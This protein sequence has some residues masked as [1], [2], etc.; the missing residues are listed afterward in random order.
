MSALMTTSWDDGYPADERLAGLLQRYGL[1]GTF[2]VPRR[3]KRPV[4]DAPR[5]RELADSFELGAHTIN[6]IVLPTTD[7]E[8]ARTEIYQSKDWIEQI[9]GENCTTFCF[10]QGKFC[11]RH[12][13][14]AEK[15]GFRMARTV[16]LMATS[17]PYR[18]AGLSL[19][20]TTLQAYPHGLT[21]YLINGFRRGRL[22]NVATAV[23]LGAV[24]SDW[25]TRGKR[26]IER[27]VRNS[28]VFHLWG[29]SWELDEQ[30]LW[31]DV[32]ELFRFMQKHTEEAPCVVNTEVHN[33]LQ[34]D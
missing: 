26:L 15:A 32:E 10:P 17:A 31:D 4:L 2:Y 28:G 13:R 11:S 29:H 16:E 6:H 27:V 5:L 25:V 14:M 30:D 12:V 24:S 7:D 1:T 9:T 33:R 21:T 18:R 34:V 19:Y 8:T 23:H 22:R 20:P 3:A